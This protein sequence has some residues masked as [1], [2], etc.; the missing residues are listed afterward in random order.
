MSKE[1]ALQL[2]DQLLA[3]TK[4]TRAEHELVKQALQVLAK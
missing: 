2:I 1:Q 4:L 3:Q